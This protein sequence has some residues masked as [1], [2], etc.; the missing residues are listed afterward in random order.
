MASVDI[1]KSR[2]LGS[3]ATKN[4]QDACQENERARHGG[5]CL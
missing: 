1:S 2:V 3:K 4:S 5:L